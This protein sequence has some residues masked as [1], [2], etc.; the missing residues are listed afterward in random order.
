MDDLAYA[1][2]LLSLVEFECDADR[3][4]SASA[5][6]FETPLEHVVGWYAEALKRLGRYARTELRLLDEVGL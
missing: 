6:T 3:R 1:N 4:T 5:R 2:T